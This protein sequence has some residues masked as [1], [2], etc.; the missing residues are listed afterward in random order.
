MGIF[1]SITGPTLPV[2]AQEKGQ[3][4]L[5]NFILILYHSI[6]HGYSSKSMSVNRL[7]PSVGYSLAAPLDSSLAQ[8]QALF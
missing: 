1:N 5:I 3:D 4:H 7:L 2:L 8:D 6:T